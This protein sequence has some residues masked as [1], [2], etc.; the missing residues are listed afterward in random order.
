MT[1]QITT[2]KVDEVIEAY[3]AE[4]RHSVSRV[5]GI[6]GYNGKKVSLLH[7]VVSS[8]EVQDIVKLMR[9]AVPHA[10]INTFKSE[11]FY[12]GFYLKPID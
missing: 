12:G 6:G 8:Y 5:D 4:Y 10:V 7:T 3:L 2:A 11:E 1:M 9:G